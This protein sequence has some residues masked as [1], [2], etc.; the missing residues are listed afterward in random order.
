MFYHCLNIILKINFWKVI[1]KNLQQV[2]AIYSKVHFDDVF[3][4]VVELAL[5]ADRVSISRVQADAVAGG[6]DVPV[7]DQGTATGLIILLVILWN[8]S[9]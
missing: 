2:F 5:L 9:Q 4:V 3:R 8:F 7:V 6:Q 1:R